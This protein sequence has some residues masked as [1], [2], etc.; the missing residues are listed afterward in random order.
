MFV[1]SVLL[2]SFLAFPSFVEII[3]GGA[4]QQPEVCG[5][6]L[7]LPRPFVG[8]HLPL[9]FPAFH[10]PAPEQLISLP[11][12]YKLRVIAVRLQQP[13]NPGRQIVDE[14]VVGDKVV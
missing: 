11:L 10:V 8:F 1:S 12:A 7:H 13:D 2:H 14:C 4:L 9:T 6:V 5:S 3:L